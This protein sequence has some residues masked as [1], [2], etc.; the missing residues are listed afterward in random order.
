MKTLNRDQVKGTH[1]FFQF[2]SSKLLLVPPLSLDHKE[3]N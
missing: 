2:L 3:V 1:S